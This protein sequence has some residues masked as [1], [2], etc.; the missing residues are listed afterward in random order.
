[1]TGSFQSVIIMFS[2]RQTLSL[3]KIFTSDI[4]TDKGPKLMKTKWFVGDLLLVRIWL[5]EEGD[6]HVWSDIHIHMYCVYPGDGS[7]TT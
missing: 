3:I 5:F 1:M 7:L 4:I 6:T 2:F